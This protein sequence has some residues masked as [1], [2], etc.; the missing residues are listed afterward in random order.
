MSSERIVITALIA[1]AGSIILAAAIGLAA[2]HAR[3]R[4]LDQRRRERTDAE[5]F[6]TWRPG[7][8]YPLPPADEDD[9][10]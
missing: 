3:S 2:E 7:D 1:L 5:G 10:A 4:R 6:R 9:H 8:G